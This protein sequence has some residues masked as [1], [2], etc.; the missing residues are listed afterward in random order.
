MAE[1][2]VVHDDAHRRLHV[3]IAARFTDAA[4]RNARASGV[5]RRRGHSWRALGEIGEREYAIA[6]Q[7]IAAQNGDGNRDFLGTLRTVA[8]GD[9]HFLQRIVL[10]A[11]GSGLLRE[12]RSRTRQQDGAEQNCG[13]LRP[14]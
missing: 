1:K 6:V 4:N 14:H 8:C 13:R 9:E 3:V 7:R 11:L 10:F 2:D 12:R 5:R